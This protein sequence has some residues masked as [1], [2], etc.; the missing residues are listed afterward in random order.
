ML[1]NNILVSHSPPYHPQSN[2]LA[3]RS[4][5]TARKG[6]K[7]LILQHKS[8]KVFSFN[9]LLA[10]FLLSYRTTPSTAT[11]RTPASLWLNFIPRT[12]LN[13]LNPKFQTSNLGKEFSNLPFKEG[14]LVN[15]KLSAKSPALKVISV[16]P[17]GSNRYLISVNGVLK[18]ASLNQISLA[19]LPQ[20]NVSSLPL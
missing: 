18:V 3:E 10:S 5:Q 7:K 16:R 11:G 12:H 15:V 4:V 9:Q 13:L 17:L 14:D 6:L 8:N 2:G 19:P 20:P 1:T